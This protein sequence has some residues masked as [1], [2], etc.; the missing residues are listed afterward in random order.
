M[1]RCYGCRLWRRACVEHNEHR[2]RL[3]TNP[4]VVNAWS[5]HIYKAK[6]ASDCAVGLIRNTANGVTVPTDTRD[7]EHLP[8]LC[9]DQ[10]RIARPALPS[11]PP[12]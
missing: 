2:S 1:R 11:R 6:D 8:P 3:G 4:Q 12:C 7:C 5:I 9:T 10:V